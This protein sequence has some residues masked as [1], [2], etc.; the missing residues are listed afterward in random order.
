MVSL[1]LSGL[2]KQSG[3]TE[4]EILPTLTAVSPSDIQNRGGQ[5]ITLSGTRFPDSD[6]VGTHTTTVTVGGV[7]CTNIE[8]VSST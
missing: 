3:L 2:I 8:L 6:A 4:I 5:V 7:A 1:K